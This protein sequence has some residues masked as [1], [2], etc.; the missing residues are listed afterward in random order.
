MKGVLVVGVVLA[1]GGVEARE[2]RAQGAM[3]RGQVV[4][5]QGRPLA[6]VRVEL[7][8]TGKEGRT[9][10]RTTN[11]KGGFVQVGLPAGPYTIQYTKDGYLPSVHRTTITAG[12]LTEIPTETLKASPKAPAGPEAQG[13][14]TAAEAVAKELEETYAKAMEATSAGRLDESEALFKQIL[15]AAPDLAA[16]RYNLGYVYSRKKNWPAAEAE[17]RRVIELQPERSDTYSALAAVYEATGRT[18]EAVELLSAASPRF[19]R[20]AA[21][22]FAA[23][24]AF[25]NAGDTPRA[26]AAL[27]KAR[28]LDPAR[29]E[30]YYH[31]GTLAVG[32]G[33]IDEAVAHLQ[34]YLSLSGQNPQNLETARKLLEAL[35][36]PAKQ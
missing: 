18:G 33:R 23:G 27:R 24:V 28:D 9:F 36:K 35:G 3:V 6:G 12:G 17:F 7:Q 31:L 29:V 34:T 19:E 5:E 25:L 30:A 4:D 26:E 32:G 13:L 10:V 16:A 8:Y 20:D 14:E 11:E 1:L 21:F 15:D 22:Q 2:A